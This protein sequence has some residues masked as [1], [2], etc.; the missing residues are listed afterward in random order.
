VIGPPD[1]LPGSDLL[2]F[3][4]ISRIEVPVLPL[5]QHVAEKT[6]AYTRLYGLAGRPSGR[7][8][9]LV[10]FVLIQAHQQLVLVAGDVRKALNAVFTARGT[11]DLPQ[12]LPPPPETWRVSY[13]R[14]AIGLAIPADLDE[15]YRLAA[16]FLTPILDGTVEDTCTWEPERGVW[17]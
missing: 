1:E 10:D 16:A 9:D 17:M 5:A 8:K 15:G 3:S 4:G 2:A 12:V 13:R 14:M 11:H 7:T 6:H